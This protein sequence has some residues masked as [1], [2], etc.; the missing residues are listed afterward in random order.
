MRPVTIF[1]AAV[2]SVAIAGGGVA[3]FAAGEKLGPAVYA[4]L[5]NEEAATIAAR[6]AAAN[7]YEGRLDAL[8]AEQTEL[9]NTT[10]QEEQSLALDEKKKVWA[11]DIV[12][13]DTVAKADFV[14]LAARFNALSD[15]DGIRLRSFNYDPRTADY[16]GACLAETPRTDIEWG[17][18]RHAFVQ[19]VE[20]CMIEKWQQRAP[21]PADDGNRDTRLQQLSAMAGGIGGAGLAFGFS[22]GYVV[23]STRRPARVKPAKPA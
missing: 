7:A 14:T 21:R 5:N 23:C 8:A 15:I 22:L 9:D 3:G 20:A 10:D 19:R 1:K 18:D 13:D 16:R 2:A 6:Q 11:A 17:D 12:L 4:R